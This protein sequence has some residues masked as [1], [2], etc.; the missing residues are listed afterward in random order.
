[1]YCKHYRERK[2]KKAQYNKE[3]KM[4]DNKIGIKK[5]EFHYRK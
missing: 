5:D 4:D 1:M 2:K 3:R